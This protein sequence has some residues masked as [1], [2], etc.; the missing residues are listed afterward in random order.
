MNWMPLMSSSCTPEHLQDPE[1]L[2]RY[3]RQG[4]CSSGRSE[5]TRI[6]WGLSYA[7]QALYNTVL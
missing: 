2:S 1:N 5:E 4:C 3:L 6:M 7:C